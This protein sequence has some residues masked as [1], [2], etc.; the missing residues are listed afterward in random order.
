MLVVMV[1]IA[2]I[3]EI[4]ELPAAAS[5]DCRQM[6]LED[7]KFKFAQLANSRVG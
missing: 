6:D 3:L 1:R 4:G 5:A 7:F 2:T